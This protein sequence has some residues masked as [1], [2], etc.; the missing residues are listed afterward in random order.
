MKQSK[1]V[2]KAEEGDQLNQRDHQNQLSHTGLTHTEQEYQ[3]SLIQG[4]INNQQ[5]LN[6]GLEYSIPIEIPYPLL[7]TNFFFWKGLSTNNLSDLMDFIR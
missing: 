5:N 3:E 7:C 1:A 4:K 2:H 6:K